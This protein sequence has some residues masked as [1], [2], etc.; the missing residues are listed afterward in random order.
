MDPNEIAVTILST[1]GAANYAEDK[2]AVQISRRIKEA[3][4]V[5]QHAE[6]Q[7]RMKEDAENTSQPNPERKL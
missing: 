1:P 5:D 6:E 7:H 3:L 4:A 2:E